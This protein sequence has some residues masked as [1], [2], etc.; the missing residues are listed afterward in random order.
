MKLQKQELDVDFIGGEKPLTEAEEKALSEHFK[1][2]KLDRSR[3]TAFYKTQQS[4]QKIT[5]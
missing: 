1:K 4:T 5:A 2:Q 3:K